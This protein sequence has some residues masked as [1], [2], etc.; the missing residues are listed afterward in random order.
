MNNIKIKNF[1]AYWDFDNKYGVI[2]LF[3]ADS[4]KWPSPKLA[5]DEF[6]AM[7][8]ILQFPDTS[9]HVPTRSLVKE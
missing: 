5:A 3:F 6:T 1:S 8:S 9:W 7:L 4:E 2:E